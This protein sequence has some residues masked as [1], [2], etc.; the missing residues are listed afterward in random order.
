MQ[1]KDAMPPSMPPPMQPSMQARD[2]LSQEIAALLRD[3]IIDGALEA[4]QRLNEVHLARDLGVSR[5]PLREALARL[6]AEGF[7]DQAPRRG[8]FVRGLDPEEVES[9]YAI[10]AILDPAALELAGLPDGA[11]LDRLD[12]LNR[13][14]DEERDPARII[15]L[16][17]RWHLEL[18]GHC[19]NPILLDLVR[20]LMARTRRYE[21]AY[22]RERGNVEMALDEHRRILDALRR[23][24]LAEACEAL[25][26]NMQTATGPVH[27][28]ASRSRGVDPSFPEKS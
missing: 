16:D 6:A 22:L 26:Q 9:L 10:R 4:G 8:F 27:E 17:D 2:N 12:A 18:L 5:T 7:V 19:P 25:R 14:I 13:A 3:R 1:K 24:E 21:H 28:A 20:E 11:R 15:D 23:Q